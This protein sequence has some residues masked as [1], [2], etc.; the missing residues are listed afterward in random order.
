MAASADVG[1]VARDPKPGVFQRPTKLFVGGISRHTT[2]KLMREHFM[3][4]G[5]VLDCV[6]M[7]QQ[8]GRSRGFG[9][10]T[11]DSLGAAQACLVEPQVIDGRIVDMK[12][13]IPDAMGMASPSTPQAL[14]DLDLATADAFRALGAAVEHARPRSGASERSS[15]STRED[16]AND[17]RSP[18][19][20]SVR[21]PVLLPLLDLLALDP[22][23]D[24]GELPRP[25]QSL[26]LP[27]PPAT[28]P[29]PPPS[30]FAELSTGCKGKATEESDEDAS[31]VAPSSNPSPA[32]I[33]LDPEDEDEPVED[34][35]GLLSNVEFGVVAAASPEELPSW[36]SR[37]HASRE[38]RRC[39]F[40]P[41]GRCGNGKDC[42]FC[43]LPHLKKKPSRQEK[44]ARQVVASLNAAA[45][46]PQSDSEDE[47]VPAPANSEGVLPVL[48]A[49]PGLEASKP[50]AVLVNL[51]I[52]SLEK[53]GP[54]AAMAA[55]MWRPPTVGAAA[56]T[57]P[58]A[59]PPGSRH[60]ASPGVI[61]AVNLDD[62]TDDEDSD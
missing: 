19:G 20:E 44:R 14:R 18:T 47:R 53:S 55:A 16:C 10:V 12:L 62:Y 52:K 49:P 9:Y 28:A 7:R 8:D 37:L 30:L 58:Y 27:P 38:C 41:K 60:P 13:A 15:S 54:Q 48:R 1:G 34:V 23:E 32:V 29:P 42:Q 59:V 50:A 3:Q 45:S 17:A 2:T 22:S 31:T 25:F 39:N 6:A 5:R 56:P 26:G 36:G 51:R 46:L 43:H 11:L 35:E 61:C 4:Y 40:F 33:K 57:G 21:A 24:D